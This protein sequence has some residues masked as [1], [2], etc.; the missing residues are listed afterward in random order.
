M[1]SGSLSF[2]L[3]SVNTPLCTARG[4]R[5]LAYYQL[6][7]LSIPFIV[8]IENRIIIE[9]PLPPYTIPAMIVSTI[10]AFLTLYED[11]VHPSDDGFNLTDVA[12]LGLALVASVCNASFYVFLNVVE[13]N[14]TNEELNFLQLSFPFIVALP[15]S[16]S[17]DDWSVIGNFGTTD[18]I[19][20]AFYCVGNF[21]GAVLSVFAVRKLGAPLVTTL[22]P[23]RLVIAAAF[24]TAPLL[25]EPISVLKAIGLAIVVVTLAAYLWMQYKLSKNVEK[26]GSLVE[27][28]EQI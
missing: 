1:S 2:W 22:L 23:W 17:I 3:L 21:L 25:N 9:K 27:E 6:I 19:M 11:V 15:I 26:K 16:L 24:G 7:Y 5:C 4:S 28:A 20:L 12:G 10:A 13:K 18:G 8:A 14:V